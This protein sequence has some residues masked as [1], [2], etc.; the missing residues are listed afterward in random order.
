MMIAQGV[1]RWIKIGLLSSSIA[2][3]MTTAASERGAAGPMDV[4]AGEICVGQAWARATP[5]GAQ[6]AA[7]Y[8]SIVNKGSAADLLIGASTSAATG[9]MVHRSVM[10]GN[11]VRMEMT[12]P[13]E[14]SPGANLKFAPIGY[15]VMLAGLKQR[16]TDGMTIPL[17]LD[18]A[19]AGKLKLPV[20]VLSV[21]AVGP[22]SAQPG[23]EGTASPTSSVHAGPPHH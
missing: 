19:K 14:L 8:F 23:S 10:S 17:T 16:L 18:F 22:K 13:V 15:H 9:T 12:G 7:V 3:V 11:I 20:P 2:F 6:N 5:P 1:P 4:C 21:S